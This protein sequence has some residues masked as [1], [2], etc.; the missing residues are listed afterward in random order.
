M[1]DPK[2]LNRR[3]KRIMKAL[4]Y[5]YPRKKSA[6]QIYNYISKYSQKSGVKGAKALGHILMRF[7]VKSELTVVSSMTKNRIINSRYIRLY[8]LKESFV[9]KYYKEK[10]DLM[11]LGKKKSHSSSRKPKNARRKKG[12]R[13]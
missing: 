4:L 6:S 11:K 1:F 8:A 7:P 13:K 3:D 12:K 5:Y 2:K 9:K 10:N